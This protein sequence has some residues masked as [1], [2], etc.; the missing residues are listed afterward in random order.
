MSVSASIGTVHTYPNVGLVNILLSGANCS[1]TLGNYTAINATCVVESGNRVSCSA[2]FDFGSGF[3]PNNTTLTFTCGGTTFFQATVT[4][5]NQ[6]IGISSIKLT[7][8]S[9]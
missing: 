2:T 6:L 7:E 9:S 8:T 5:Q 4:C 1:A 3:T